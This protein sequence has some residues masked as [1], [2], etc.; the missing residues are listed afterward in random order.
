MQLQRRALIGATLGAPV[1][2]LATGSWSARGRT[3]LQQ[4]PRLQ[5]LL[6]FWQHCVGLLQPLLSG[7]SLL[8]R[9]LCRP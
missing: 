4:D 5:P 3:V 7:A 9:A 2:L 8:S 1:L 6:E